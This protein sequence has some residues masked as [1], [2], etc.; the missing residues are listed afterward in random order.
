VYQ[1]EVAGRRHQLGTSGFLYRSNKLMYDHATASLWSTLQGIPVVGRLVREDIRLPRLPVV[2]T[3]WGSWRKRHPRT[4]VLSLQ[5]GHDRDYSEGAAYREYFA[6]DQLMFEVPQKDSRL[7]NKDPVLALRDG[8]S[9]L[10]IATGFLQQNPVFHERLG[11]RPLVILTEPSGASRVYESGSAGFVSWDG[12]AT[13]TDQQGHSW[14]VTEQALIRGVQRL[15]RVPAHRAFWFGW[16]AQY[17]ETRLVGGRTG[18]PGP[19]VDVIPAWPAGMRKA[20]SAAGL[21]STAYSSTSQ[22]LLR[23]TTLAQ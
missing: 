13:V 12:L 6:T 8:Q 15:P 10:A 3:T 2:T 5:T 9:Q 21:R 19:T 4:T 16:Y 1:T 18:P 14:Q 7:S 23:R 11:A 17:P 22:M 20:L